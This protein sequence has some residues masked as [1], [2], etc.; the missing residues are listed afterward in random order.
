MIDFLISI[1]FNHTVYIKISSSKLFA[2]YVEKN[3]FIEERPLLA[4]KKGKNGKNRV[5]GFGKDATIAKSKDHKTIT[6]H[7]AFS[8]PRTFVSNFE[9]AEATL[10]QLIYLVVQ[11]RFI[12]RPIVILHPLEKLEGGITQIEFRGLMELGESIGCRKVYIWTGATLADNDL[13][14]KTFLENNCLTRADSTIS[15][16]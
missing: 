8:H 5:V 6:V 16:I 14:D 9:V 2:R 4:I 15:E 3:R 11:R 13:L 7:N 1:F 12:V 10:R